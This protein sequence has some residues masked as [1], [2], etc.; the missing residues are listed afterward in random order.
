MAIYT[1]E[2]D[3][4]YATDARGERLAKDDP[5]FE[6]LG[7]LD[8]L[9]AQLG[10]CVVAAERDGLRTIHDALEQSQGELMSVGT[11][12]AG[13]A[14]SAALDAEPV[15]RM[16]TLIDECRR[17][18]GELKHFILPG[19][20]ESACRLHVARTVCRRC[21]RTVVKARNSGVS[22]PPAVLQYLNRLG[23]LLFSL[24]RLANHQTG[25]GD[26]TW[27]P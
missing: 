24:A 21:E 27:T 13:L 9:N 10:L 16:E 8:E 3:D 17:Q 5:R 23:D 25:R 15:K 1:R 4:G 22:V 2:G 19:G 20:C 26:V 11:I 14:T 18:A 12:V 7:S 6:A